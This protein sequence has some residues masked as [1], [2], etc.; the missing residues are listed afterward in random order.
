MRQ[1]ARPPPP[2][3]AARR[4]ETTPGSTPTQPCSASCGSPL[5]GEAFGR[6]SGLT[7]KEY[8]PGSRLLSDRAGSPPA[9]LA[10]DIRA[11]APL[12]HACAGTRGSP[13]SAA[14]PQ[15]A[16][17]AQERC[18][19]AAFGAGA[20]QLDLAG[21][22]ARRRSQWRGYGDMAIARQGGRPPCRAIAMSPYPRHW[23]RRRANR[24]ARSSCRAPAPNAASRHR[25]C[26]RHATCGWAA[27]VG[28]PRVPAQACASGA[29]ARISGARQAGGDPA[30]SD[31]S[32]LP[33]RYSFLVNPEPRPKAS[34]ASGLPQ[35]AEH[36]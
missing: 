35:E 12:A 2:M 18:R 20:R 5:A 16:W 9:C 23:L 11:A 17:R 4:I 8:R 33:G 6:G 28:D 10:P 14:Q 27:D 1:A 29:A 15:V 7:R 24:P 34:P 31:R 13:T 22:F 30:R 26:A 19:L 36:G 32:L 3:T 25:S 21:R